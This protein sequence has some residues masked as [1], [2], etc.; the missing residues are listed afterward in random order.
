MDVHETAG[1]QE[2]EVSQFAAEGAVAV[3]VS[4]LVARSLCRAEAQWSAVD[5]SAAV[6]EHVPET[7]R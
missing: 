5:G 7:V 2:S 4:R 1:R 6:S 3:E